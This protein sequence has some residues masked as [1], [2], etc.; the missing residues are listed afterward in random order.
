MKP[1]VTCNETSKEL[2]SGSAIDVTVNVILTPLTCALLVNEFFKGLLYQTDQIPYPFAR[3]KSMVERRRSNSSSEDLNN[4]KLMQHFH[5]V[6]TSYDTLINIMKG[7]EQQF[8]VCNTYVTEVVIMFGVTSFCPKE[9]FRINIPSATAKHSPKHHTPSVN[10]NNKILRNIFLS[11]AWLD[12]LVG[13]NMPC[14]NT[15]IFIKKVVMD[16]EDLN[17]D[18]IFVP[19]SFTLPTNVKITNINIECSSLNEENCCDNLTIFN[20][21]KCQLKTGESSSCEIETEQNF[22]EQWYECSELFRGFKDVFINKVSA[23]EL[24]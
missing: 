10:D 4:F 22:S 18:S 1:E 21:E 2:K 16:A 17:C 9:V 14:T 19:T 5:L 6:S 24:W 3:V 8:T 12:G 11:Q 13:K 20:D 23:C 15:Y 7:I